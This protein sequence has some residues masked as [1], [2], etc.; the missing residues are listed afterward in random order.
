MVLL[1]AI[2]VGISCRHG[3]TEA[4]LNAVDS[5]ETTDSLDNDSTLYL[6]EED[7][8]LSLEEHA[9][10]AFGD[11][12]FAFTH[13]SRF[14][15][16]RI[17]FP[18]PG[19]DLDGT[20]RTVRSGRQFRSEFR[21]PGNEYY[22]LLLGRR[23]QMTVMQDDTLITDIVLQHIHL[24]QQTMV[25][26]NFHRDNGHWYLIR[27]NSIPVAAELSSFFQF[28]ERF[29]TD[30]LYQQESIATHLAFSMEAPD[31]D[32]AD[33]EGTIDR[34]QWPVFRPEMPG[35]EFVNVDF[36][37]DFPDPSRILML[38]CGI[39]NGMLDIFTFHREGDRWELIAY[40]N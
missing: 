28:Y 34:D 24:H 38:Q 7:E 13:N 2:A 17:R 10:E 15:A 30:S 23:E 1:T 12:F 8:G 25:C 20:E 39:S 11:F 35:E 40:E 27:R 9:T 22:T 29:T 4:D 14:Q 5:T 16:E 32:E 33:I 19:T 21:L 36:G 3:R 31:E 26:Y 18:L 6:E 37:Q